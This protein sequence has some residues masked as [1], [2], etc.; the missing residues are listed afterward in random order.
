[1]RQGPGRARGGVAGAGEG[2][3]EPHHG[4][5]LDLSQIAGRVDDTARCSYMVKVRNPDTP[6]QTIYGHPGHRRNLQLEVTTHRLILAR[7]Y[8]KCLAGINNQQRQKK[9][10]KERELIREFGIR[11]AAT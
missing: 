2:H 6:G 5:A 3:A 8:R 11:A 7:G 9:T 4:S 1:M 10:M